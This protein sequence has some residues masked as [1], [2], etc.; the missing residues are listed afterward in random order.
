MLPWSVFSRQLLLAVTRLMLANP[1]A[2]GSAQRIRVAGLVE[3]F[4][5][6]AFVEGLNRGLLIGV[7]GEH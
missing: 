6:V 7:A 4:E 3:E 2:H 5:D 1:L